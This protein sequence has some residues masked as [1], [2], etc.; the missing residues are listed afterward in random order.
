LRSSHVGTVR[1]RHHYTRGPRQK[2]CDVLGGAEH[3][4]PEAVCRSLCTQ[5]LERGTPKSLLMIPSTIR[6][7]VK[8]SDVWSE[9]EARVTGSLSPLGFRTASPRRPPCALRC[10]AS[11]DCMRVCERVEYIEEET[12]VGY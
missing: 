12:W 9:K 11:Q 7:Y 3:D 5:A 8:G 1:T 4:F 10:P 6:G 2:C